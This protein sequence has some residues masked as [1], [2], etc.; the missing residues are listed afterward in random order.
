MNLIPGVEGGLGGMGN[1]GNGQSGDW[2]TE[3][4]LCCV[5]GLLNT[6]GHGVAPVCSGT[7]ITSSSTQLP[8]DGIRWMLDLSHTFIPHPVGRSNK[9]KIGQKNEGIGKKLDELMDQL[10][11]RI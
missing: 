6:G 8:G 9:R 1:E 10:G 7:V 2:G 11:S 4:E 5:E 3:E